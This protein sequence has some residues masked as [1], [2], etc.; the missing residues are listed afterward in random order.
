[1]RIQRDRVRSFDPGEGRPSA[2]GELEEATV[3][4]VDVEPADAITK[5]GMR[6]AT[7]SDS[8]SSRSASISI[9]SSGVHG[10]ERTF[11]LGKPAIAAAFALDAWTCSET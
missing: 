4:G 2:F 10:T 5:N 6:P 3:R 11:A 7:R 1:M 9:L 8:S